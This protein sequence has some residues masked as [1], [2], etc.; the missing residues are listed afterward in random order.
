MFHKHAFFYFYDYCGH[1]A[2]DIDFRL[3]FSNIVVSLEIC[4]SCF[5]GF[6]SY[7]S[8][9]ISIVKCKKIIALFND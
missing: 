7:F 1:L 5:A 6:I 2:S 4:K 8:E 9:L 3:L